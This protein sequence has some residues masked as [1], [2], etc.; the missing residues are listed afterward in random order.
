MANKKR[1]LGVGVR[2]VEHE[3]QSP[4]VEE[5]HPHGT[6]EDPP[7]L[8]RVRLVPPPQVNIFGNKIFLK[9]SDSNITQ[10]PKNQ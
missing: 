7:A 5:G 4:H 3:S 9:R 1:T 8:A 10:P 6:E 2:R